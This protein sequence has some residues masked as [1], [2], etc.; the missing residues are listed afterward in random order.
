H[1]ITELPPPPWRHRQVNSR[2]ACRQWSQ[3]TLGGS[4]SQEPL[5]SPSRIWFCAF[6]EAGER[7]GLCVPAEKPCGRKSVCGQWRQREGITMPLH[8]WSD[9][10]DWDSVHQLWINSLLYW[11]QDR[12]PVGYRAYLGSLPPL[13]PASA[14]TLVE[15]P[16][17]DF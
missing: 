12:L 6:L 9:D 3:V 10:R 11:I 13:P 5:T 14:E 16:Q 17:P 4:G 7:N 1:R 2:K 15:G 8:D